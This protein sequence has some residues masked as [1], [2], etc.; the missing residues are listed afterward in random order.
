MRKVIFGVAN[1]LDNYIARSDGAVDWLMWSDELA[2][3]IAEFWKRIDTVV[4]GRKTYDVGVRESK[5]NP[6]PYPDMKTYIC[7][8]T[9]TPQPE[10]PFE[11]A[12][13][14]VKLVRTL[15]RKRGKA[16][17]IMGGGELAHPLFE[18][19]LIDE[20]GVSIHPVL[21][22]SGI[23]LFHQMRRQIDLRLIESKTF[24]NG[25]V[26]ASYAVKH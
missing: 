2:G 25:C 1:S 19:G 13:D 24:K 5:G 6:N 22:G 4:M 17:C 11:I 9:L 16:I 20:V 26:L 10:Q 23:P 7:S 15:K 12:T 21:L 18:A 3:F 8:R 14:V